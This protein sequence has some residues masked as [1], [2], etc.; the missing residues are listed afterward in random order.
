MVQAGAEKVSIAGHETLSEV[1]VGYPR[2][3]ISEYAKE[4][5][6]DLIMAGSHGRSAIGRFLRAAWRRAYFARLTVP[7]RSCV[8]PKVR[9]QVRLIP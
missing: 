7:W 4:W 2:R 9:H 8:Q 5:K 3:N 1:M 6:A